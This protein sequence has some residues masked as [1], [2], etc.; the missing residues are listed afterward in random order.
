MADRAERPPEVGGEHPDVRAL[1]AADREVDPVA[2]PSAELEALD[3]HVARLALDLDALAGELVERHPAALERRDTSAA[4]AALARRTC[5]AARASAASSN[6]ATGGARRS[7]PVRSRVSVAIPSRIVP[8]TPSLREEGRDLG[9]FAEAERQE[10]ARE[11]IERAEMPDLGAAEPALER[12]DDAGR[13]HALGL[14]D[15][16]DPVE[17]PLVLS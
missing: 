2:P 7:S 14:V 4:S 6:A 5:A 8:R 3:R 15:E 1:G 9:G 11:R 13:R 16:E 10:P 12:A 17:R